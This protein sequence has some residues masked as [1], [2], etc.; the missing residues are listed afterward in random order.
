MPEV[1]IRSELDMFSFDS[2][3]FSQFIPEV[4]I[5]SELDMF[6]FELN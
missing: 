4:S 1:S 2:N 6:S 5:Q 3:Q